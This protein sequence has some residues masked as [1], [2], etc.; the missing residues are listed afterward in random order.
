MSGFDTLELSTETLRDLT[1]DELTMA[2]GGNATLQ[3]CVYTK[4]LVN[5]IL[6]AKC[7]SWNTEQCHQQLT[8][9]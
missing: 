5:E 1:R 8:A 9:R 6:S 2:A 4:D 7:Y 3:G